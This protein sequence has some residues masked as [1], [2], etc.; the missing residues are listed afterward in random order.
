MNTSLRE[1]I[2]VVL[3]G[4]FINGVKQSKNEI[5]EFTTEEYAIQQL[6]L[7][8]QEWAESCL[9]EKKHADAKGCVHGC[10]CFWGNRNDAIDDM[11]SKLKETL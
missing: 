2:Q 3:R 11:R 1:K 8:F 5:A 9:P 4:A 10:I 6:E 7:L